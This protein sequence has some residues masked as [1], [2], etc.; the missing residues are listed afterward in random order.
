MTQGGITMEQRL[1]GI[2]ATAKT[3]SHLS[4]EKLVGFYRALGD[5]TR[6]HILWILMK[7]ELCVRNIAHSMGMTESAVSRQLRELRG[8]KLV[9]S[10]RDKQNIYYSINEDMDVGTILSHTLEHVCNTD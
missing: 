8:V 6:M 4:M 3:P 7:G 9:K 2:T 5:G 1:I 10:R